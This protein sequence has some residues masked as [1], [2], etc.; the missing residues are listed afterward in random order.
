MVSQILL[1]REMVVACYGNE[2]SFGIMLS[3][4]LLW[5]GVGSLVGG[6]WARRIARPE[7]ALSILYLFLGSLLPA[8]LLLIRSARSWSGMGPGEVMSLP[9]I[10]LLSLLFNLPL[11][12]LLGLLFVFNARLFGQAGGE[13]GPGVSLVYLWEAM[14]AFLGGILSTYLLIPHLSNLQI[15]FLILL[16]N[17]FS[18]L[19]FVGLSRTASILASGL[20]L[21]GFLILLFLQIPSGLD[22]LSWKW[23]WRDLNL[24][25]TADSIY[26]NIAVGERYGQTS[27]YENGLHLFSS[28]DP[29]AA[30]E[31]VHYALLQHPHPHSLF[32]IGG[33]IGGGLAQAL[34][35]PNLLIDYAELDPKI[36]DVAVR[37][38]PSEG[39]ALHDI[40][41]KVQY[42]DGRALL[43]NSRS[44]YDVIILN[45]PD[46]HTLQLNRFYTR[47]FF[48]IVKQR[49][50][51]G[52]VF[53]FRV[54][55][56][57]NYLSPDQAEYLALLRNT[58]QAVFPEVVA[59]PGET[60]IF[61]ASL[62]KGL[63]LRT[64]KGLISR[65]QTRHLNNQY[66]SEF[67]IPF[68]L[69]PF[70]MRYLKE[71]LQGQDRRMN[72]DLEPICYLYESALWASQFGSWER[73]IFSFLFQVS[74]GYILL[75]LLAPLAL[76]IASQTVRDSY[77]SGSVLG[78]VFVTGLTSI[79]LEVT[80]LL[81]FQIFYGFIYHEIGLLLAAFM[82][83]LT[84]GASWGKRRE[85]SW[86]GLLLSQ[87]ILTGLCFLFT[88][89]LKRLNVTAI[90]F[91]G[92]NLLFFLSLVAVGTVG[93]A[94][95]CLASGIYMK[96]RSHPPWGT[97][98]AIDLWGSA[99]GA[100]LF[101]ALL[102]PRWGMSSSLLLLAL[103]NLTVLLAL[104]LNGVRSMRRDRSS[105]P[106]GAP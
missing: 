14:G 46:P 51:P 89:G 4:W 29:A 98:Y 48:E 79:S 33:G 57:E 61:F 35:Y 83:G 42:G 30:E 76:L 74:W 53:S 31:A 25:E 12:L 50:S 22:L 10:L 15:S 67:L 36:I 32:L 77:L 90:P 92:M 1:L 69:H 37:H 11:C 13:G 54:S 60:C 103:L 19:Y 9:T 38:L 66:V 45:L 84:I 72:K 18:A 75:L 7:K 95:F 101:S 64:D 17:L 73:R 47:E 71:R 58:L 26:G 86:K 56:S 91:A 65:L 16:L 24:R 85:G 82:L 105:L 21:L 96:R 40:R 49:L 63:L 78:S 43:R 20:F 23:H 55:S 62:Q 34:K 68:R 41:V 44:H 87:A 81:A 52:G 5:V 88:L 2:L 94:Q 97:A 70:K 3:A 104:S 39:E 102:I 99:P 106:Q 59:F 8:S 93:G 27:L 6:A 28:P 80:A 100:L